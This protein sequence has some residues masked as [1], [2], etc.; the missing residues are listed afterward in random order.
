MHTDGED[1]QVLRQPD[2]QDQKGRQQSEKWANREPS[3]HPLL[4]FGQPPAPPSIALREMEREERKKWGEERYG[5]GEGELAN[6][7][8]TGRRCSVNDSANGR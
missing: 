5:H 1:R 6:Y 2:R 8:G 7:R 4:G 3:L